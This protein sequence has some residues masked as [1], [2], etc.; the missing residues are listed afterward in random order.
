VPRQS[1]SGGWSAGSQAGK[2]IINAPPVVLAVIAVLVAIH[3]LR[4]VA[5]EGWDRWALI[6]VRIGSQW[7]SVLTY[8]F[9]HGDWLHLA[10]NS[11]WLLVF[12]TPVARWFG[13][14]RFLIIAALSAIGG[15][16]VMLVTDWGSTIPIVG[17]SGAV[18]GLMA[19][20]IPVMYG[21]MGRPLFP[22]ELLRDRRA[23]I[24]V[25]IWLAITLLTGAQTYFDAEGIRIAWQAH[26]GGFISGFAVYAVMMHR[27]VR[28]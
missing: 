26:I 21:R 8:A 4:M 16:V 15:A 3:A 27:L 22:G 12:G 25:V 18:S 20:A 9:L 24:F 28:A 6:P 23:L 5:G 14:A 7:W 11:L 10:V 19:A 2:G 13:A 17:A 1:E